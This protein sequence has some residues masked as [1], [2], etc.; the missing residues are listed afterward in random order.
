MPCSSRTGA[1]WSNGA[2]S[3]TSF[4]L[5]MF[6][7]LTVSSAHSAR[8]DL[9]VGWCSIVTLPPASHT[10]CTAGPIATG[11]AASTAT[12]S[13]LASPC[14][15]SAP[16]ITRACSWT[17]AH[18]VCTGLPGSPVVTPRRCPPAPA[19]AISLSTKRLMRQL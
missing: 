14:L 12:A 1:S 5:I 13:P 3:S 15:T 6:R 7:T 16:A 19:V 10:A 9:G 18:V 17:C 8:S 11:S 4:E 2:P